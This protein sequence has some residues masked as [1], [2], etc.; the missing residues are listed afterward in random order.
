MGGQ[1]GG[2]DCGFLYFR[3]GPLPSQAEHSLWC[4]G[5]VLAEGLCSDSN[6]GLGHH[7]KSHEVF[8]CCRTVAWPEGFLDTISA[9]F[10]SSVLRAIPSESTR[11][12]SL[13]VECGA[14]WLL[15]EAPDVPPREVTLQSSGTHVA[16]RHEP[17]CSFLPTLV[18]VVQCE[19][20]RDPEDILKK[21]PDTRNEISSPL[22]PG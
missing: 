18:K 10:I 2:L 6:V 4:W 13:L 15:T 3:E 16:G 20:A 22:S 19:Y 9:N 11:D 12:T 21:H 17:L 14:V 1:K 5:R 7:W 8:S